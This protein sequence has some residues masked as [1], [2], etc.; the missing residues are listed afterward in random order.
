MKTLSLVT[1]AAFAHILPILGTL[2]IACGGE[3]A[4]A[5]GLIV[6]ILATMVC[7]YIHGKNNSFS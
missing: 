4:R 3:V 7:G 5:L 2:M 1:F 6:V